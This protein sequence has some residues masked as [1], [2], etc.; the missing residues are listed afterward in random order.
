MKYNKITNINAGG[1]YEW[2][3][4][5]FCTFLA[6]LGIPRIK[7]LKEL[8]IPPTTWDRW[9]STSVMPVY[10]LVRICNVTH[11]PIARFI[12]S[13]YQ[14]P[15]KVTIDMQWEE[16][17]FTPIEY[18]PNLMGD[19]LTYGRG[20]SVDDTCAELGIHPTYFYRHFRSDVISRL[21]ISD[22]LKKCNACKMWPGNWLIDDNEPII[23]LDGFQQVA[24]TEEEAQTIKDKVDETLYL[25]RE[26]GLKKKEIEKLKKQIAEL[27]GKKEEAEFMSLVAEDMV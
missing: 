2:D 19:Y 23:L 3:H 26:L 25:K 8:N 7:V 27:S 21:P 5:L 6:D 11:I 10:Q 15:G 16:D 1:E 24:F 22:Y 18:K 9:R 20:R 17:I 4:A 14:S 12:K 13:T